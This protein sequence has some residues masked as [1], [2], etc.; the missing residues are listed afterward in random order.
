MKMSLVVDGVRS[1]VVTVGELGDDTVAEVAE[2]IADLVGRSLPARILELLSDVAAEVSAEL[3]EGRVEIRVAGDDV[4]LAYVEE[5]RAPIGGDGD[6]DLSS[7]ITL[8][9]SERLKA[10]VEEDAGREG[11]SV[12]TF[13]VHTLERGASANRHRGSGGTN[14]LRGYGTT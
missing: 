3:P 10:Q 8:R 6:A 1:D 4:A 2:R 13:I 11:V 12:N 14:R 9:L 5:T 7:R